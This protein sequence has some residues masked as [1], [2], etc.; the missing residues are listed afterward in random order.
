MTFTNGFIRLYVAVRRN[1]QQNFVLGDKLLRAETG[2]D[3]PEAREYACSHLSRSVP[4]FV[5]LFTFTV[6]FH[7]HST[8]LS[9]VVTDCTVQ[10]YWARPFPP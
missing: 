9:T 4:S 1:T 7:S 8:E 2:A 6:K 3:P 10:G 5:H